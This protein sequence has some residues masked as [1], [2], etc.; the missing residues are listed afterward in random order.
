MRQNAEGRK[1]KNREEKKNPKRR[2]DRLKIKR[3]LKT[4]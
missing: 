1:R 2:I 4:N 3:E